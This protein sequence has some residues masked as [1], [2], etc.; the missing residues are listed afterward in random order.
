M[1][2]SNP[3]LNESDAEAF[4][5]L[6]SA[7]VDGTITTAGQAD[8]EAR[9]RSDR[10]VRDAFR[11]FLEIESMLAWE[12]RRLPTVPEHQGPSGDR[13]SLVRVATFAAP[14]AALAAACAAVLAMFVT[15][16]LDP[17][18]AP[19]LVATVGHVQGETDLRVA[20]RLEIG[21]RITL[22]SGE[23]LVRF[24]C[25]AE[26]TLSGPCVLEIEAANRAFLERGRVWTRAEGATAKGFTIRTLRSRIVDL[27]TEFVTSVAADGHNRVDVVSGEVIVHLT[28]SLASSLLR[29]GEMLA[30]EPGGRNVTVRIERGDET[31]AFRCSAI[32]PPSSD[33]FADASLGQARVSVSGG[34]LFVCQPLA[35]L[36]SGGID[37]L[38]DGRAQENCDAPQ[39]SVFSQ[40]HGPGAFLFDLGR[41]V[42]L[43]KVNS[44]SWHQS[45]FV[46]ENHVR[47]TQ[48]YTLSGHPGHG[49]AIVPPADDPG[50]ERIARVNT[51]AY[52]DVGIPR[53]RPAQQAT[54]VSSETGSLGRFR[55]LRFDVE[56]TR[57]P[58]DGE[59]DHT[60]YGE[61]DIYADP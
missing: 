32:E 36:S 27:G 60:F 23:V 58:H 42:T 46:S 51:D 13:G 34:T 19:P 31:P 26:A 24:D 56:P 11:W 30:I 10:D 41:T 14:I 21:R 18:G 52:F 40:E 6:F 43:R 3:A 54:S 57:A 53:D 29:Q 20:E 25:G 5:G 33:D 39:E 15:P 12:V 37:R 4:G 45:R 2:H 1:N 35:E 44:F 61:I 49:D 38:V 9:L 16:G 48:K 7:L 47:A 8:L 17:A 50:W 22:G 59:C 55:F 28:G